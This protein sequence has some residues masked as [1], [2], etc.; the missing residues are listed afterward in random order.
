MATLASRRA[1]QLQTTM[2]QPSD[3]IS[4]DPEG[5]MALAIQAIQLGQIKSSRAAAKVY[6][7]NR[8]TLDL[9]LY[10]IQA[11]R[12]SIPHNRNL[13]PSEESVIVNY[14]LDLDSRGFSPR[15]CVVGEIANLLLDQRQGTHVG[16]NWTTRFINRRPEI[17][18]I[19]N[20]KHDYKR[21]LC[22]DLEVIGKWFSL[23]SNVIAK[24]GIAVDDIHNFD[25]SGFLMGMIATAK[26]VTGVESRNR[27]KAAQPGNREWVTVIQGVNSQGWAIPPFII[28]SGQYHLSAWYTDDEL[29]PDWAIAVSENG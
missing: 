7:V 26:V 25:K 14:V 29:L 1:P 5:R 11:R 24:Y 2:P 21:L 22:Q 20:R 8:T 28:L 12:D 9:R 18:S 17:K 19:F 6:F 4:T 15:V 3:I 13:T 27:P 10:G 16:Q 23:V